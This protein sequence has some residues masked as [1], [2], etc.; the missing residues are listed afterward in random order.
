MRIVD[1]G[2]TLLKLLRGSNLELIVL[3]FNITLEN[4]QS[5]LQAHYFC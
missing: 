5:E 3:L 2:C 4:N 1:S